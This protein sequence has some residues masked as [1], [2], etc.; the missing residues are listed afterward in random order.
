MR[1]GAYCAIVYMSKYRGQVQK[2]VGVDKNFEGGVCL[3][4]FGFMNSN[5]HAP[6][7]RHQQVDGYCVFDGALR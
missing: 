4:S 3:R 7:A 5:L 1:T 2:G 6:G